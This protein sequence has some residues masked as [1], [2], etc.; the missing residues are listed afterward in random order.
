MENGVHHRPDHRFQEDRPKEFLSKNRNELVEADQTP[1]A[2]VVD[3]GI[4]ERQDEI[5]D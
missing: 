4:R 1:V 2:D 3:V 5:E